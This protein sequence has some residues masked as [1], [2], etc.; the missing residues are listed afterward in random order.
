LNLQVQSKASP[1]EICGGYFS[2]SV[3]SMDAPF[4]YFIYLL[5]TFAADRIIKQ[6]TRTTHL[7]AHIILYKVWSL[8]APDLQTQQ[9]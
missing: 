2:L 6:Q 7:Q 9:R 3:S 8:Q 5:L 1:R 4:S